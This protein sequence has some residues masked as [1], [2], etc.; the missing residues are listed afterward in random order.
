MR[1]GWCK[2]EGHQIRN[3]LAIGVQEER[4]RRRE[5]SQVKKGK[6]CE[7]QRKEHSISLNAL[8]LAR[9]TLVEGHLK[10]EFADA[11][12]TPSGVLKLLFPG[13]F[14]FPIEQ[15][16]FERS[17]SHAKTYAMIRAIF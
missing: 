12:S 6:R 9:P 15:S 3:C 7:A 11:C 14:L 2:V 16:I 1:C 13:L 10:E 5:I 17:E 8:D 4:E